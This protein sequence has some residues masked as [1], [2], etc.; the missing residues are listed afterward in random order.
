MLTLACGFACAASGQQYTAE[1]LNLLAAPPGAPATNYNYVSEGGAVGDGLGPAT[2]NVPHALHMPLGASAP[3]DLHPSGFQE[4]YGL[5]GSG[6]QQVGYG[7]SASPLQYR[8][9]LW[10]GSAGSV[11][12]LQPPG[13]TFSRAYSTDGVEQV[14]IASNGSG[15]R[16]VS[17]V[18]TAS[19][20]IILHPGGYSTSHAYG[21]G[22]GQQC[23]WAFLPS[24][25]LL[26]RAMV[27]T[28]TPESAVD[29][30]SPP[31]TETFAFDT[32]GGK[33]VGYGKASSAPAIRALMWSGTAESVVDLHPS[34]LTSSVAYG[35]NG[36]VQVGDGG[37]GAA[38]WFGSAESYVDLHA[39]LPAGFTG[40]RAY[41]VGADGVIYGRAFG[42]SAGGTG[43]H[44]VKWTPIDECAAKYNDGEEPDI[45]DFLDFVDDFSTCEGQPA[46]CGSFGEA[47]INGDTFVDILDFLDFIDSFGTGC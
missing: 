24:A 41:S 11:V 9:L 29:L 44:A 14:G 40:S 23:G 28:G 12:D 27:W 35:T 31:Y 10:S 5:G 25:P 13:Y 1:V 38:A 34:G 37:P 8:A 19:T 16:A 15:T 2:G 18:G 7:L 4:S 22:D 6:G 32:S 21:V 3:I 42:T 30:H 46:P 20:A 45:L 47:D 33:Q 17:W 39:F 36:E 26:A 43:Y